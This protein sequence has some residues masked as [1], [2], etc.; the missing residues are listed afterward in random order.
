MYNGTSRSPFSFV[1]QGYLNRYGYSRNDLI[2]IPRNISAI[3]LKDITANDG[4]IE[5]TATEQWEALNTYIESNNYLK[6]N[7]GGYAKT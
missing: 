3:N 6:N 2:Y 1:Y 5:Q 4:F 7:R